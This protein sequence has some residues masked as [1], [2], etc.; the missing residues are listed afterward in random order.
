MKLPFN[1]HTRAG[2]GRADLHMHSIFWSFFF[3]FFSTFVFFSG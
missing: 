3:S 1:Q 2:P